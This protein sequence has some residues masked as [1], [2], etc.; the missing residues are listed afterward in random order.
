MNTLKALLSKQLWSGSRFNVAH[1]LLVLAFG[2]TYLPQLQSVLDAM[3]LKQYDTDILESIKILMSLRMIFQQWAPNSAA[4]AK[5][6]AQ[7]PPAL[8]AAVGKTPAND[9][10]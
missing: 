5:D 6:A 10:K 9:T 8:V 7:A 3:G 2:I 4:A 1:L